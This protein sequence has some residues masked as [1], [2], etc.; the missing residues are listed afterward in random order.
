MPKPANYSIIAGLK[1]KIGKDIVGIIYLDHKSIAEIRD[2]GKLFTNL[3]YFQ[4]LN[5]IH[6]FKLRRKFK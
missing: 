5:F 2:R 1:E 6:N 3:I 4:F